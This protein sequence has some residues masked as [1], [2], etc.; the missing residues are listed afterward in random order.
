[1]GRIQI[2]LPPSICSVTDGFCIEWCDTAEQLFKGNRNCFVISG[3]CISGP[4][5]YE[6]CMSGP[7]CRRPL[8]RRK[9]AAFG[10]GKGKSDGLCLPRLVKKRFAV[11]VRQWPGGAIFRQAQDSSPTDRY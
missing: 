5:V 10:K 8:G 1:M 4:F 6:V 3:R 2:G 11:P 9:Y 7:Q